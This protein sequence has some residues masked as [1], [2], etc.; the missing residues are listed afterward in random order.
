MKTLTRTV[1][2]RIFGKDTE[3]SN[4]LYAFSTGLN[5]T[6]EYA[7]AHN[8]WSNLKLH[9]AL[10]HE[11][12][13][14]TGLLAQ[15]TCSV[16]RHVAATYKSSD[17]K[18]QDK[19]RSK[20]I[21]FK[22]TSMLLQKGRDW[23]ILKTGELSISTLSGRIIAPVKLNTHISAYFDG[24]WIFGAAY[25][26]SKSGKFY[27][28]ISCTKSIQ[29]ETQVNNIVGVDVGMNYLAVASNLENK[30][31]FYGGGKIKDR[32][33]HYL[34]VRKSLQKKGTRGAKKLLKKLSGKQ[35]R[36]QKDVNH[37]VSKKIVQFASDSGKSLI[38]LEDLTNI[39][40]T[41]RHKKKQRSNFHNWGFYQLRS[42][43][44]YKAEA[45]T[46][47]VAF[48][49]PKNTSKGCSRC[50]NVSDGQRLRH[51]FR[52][53]SC[54]FELHSDLNASRNIAQRARINRQDLLVPGLPS[55]SLKMPVAEVESV[56]SD[57][58]LD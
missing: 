48:V 43:I 4:V 40:V 52:C 42:F 56:L 41:T 29:E 54:G 7:V 49:N 34:R 33:R 11:I 57:S 32:N 39:R 53:K 23:N 22:P 16:F 37:C 45:K 12:R 46:L 15:M 55:I 58:N 24:S 38:A 3:I 19:L 50:G 25:L 20:I 8:V 10:Y 30:T 31:L 47:S 35:F 21:K 13:N 36:F 2:V 44:T 28:N 14:K 27:L 5:L 18:K 1:S 26:I 17:Q 9:Y 6:S 51:T